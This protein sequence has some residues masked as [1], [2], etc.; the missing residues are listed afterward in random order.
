MVQI[1]YLADYPQ[2]ID[3]LAPWVFAHWQP[4]LGEV[5]PAERVAKFRTHLNKEILPIALVAH[6]G[7]K[8][9]GT[10]SLRVHDLPGREDLSPWLGGVF[11]GVAYRGRGIGVQLCS[12]VE[13][14][15]FAMFPSQPWYLFTLDKQRW[16]QQQGWALREPC[17]WCGHAGVIMEKQLSG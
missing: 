3:T 9:L 8:V 13:D 12:A 2:F 5:S 17:V 6:D 10:A 11:V 14:K 7:D 4:L 15:A 1:S 16:Y